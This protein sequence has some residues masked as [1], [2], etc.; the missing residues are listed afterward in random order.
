MPIRVL[1]LYLVVLAD[2]LFRDPELNPLP[3]EPGRF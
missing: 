3:F 1:S 2:T